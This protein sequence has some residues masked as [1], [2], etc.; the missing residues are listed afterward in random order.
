MRPD[1]LGMSSYHVPESAGLLKLDAMENPYGLP[2]GLRQALGRRLASVAINRY[3][4]PAYAD[5]K[6]S[7]RRCFGVPAAA[8]LVLGNGSDELITMLVTLLNRPGASILAPLPSFVMYAMTAQFARMEFVG[9]DLDDSFQIDLAATL[10]AIDRH[11]PA[12]VFIAYPN[13]PTGNCF[14]REAVEAILRRAPGLVVLDEAY[15]PFAPDSWLSRLEEFPNLAIMRTLSKLGL[16]GAR[17]GYLVAAPAWTDQVEKVRPPYNISVL[18]EAAV[19]FALEHAD[20]FADQARSIRE[21]RETVLTALGELV[22]RGLERVYPSQANFVLVRVAQAP[23]AGGHVPAAA[24]VARRMRE[25]GVLIKDVGKM[26]PMLQNCLR[27]TVGT[28]Q[29]NQTLL[30]ALRQALPDLS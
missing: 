26:H 6:T 5:L 23:E 15:E 9:V 22:G 3:P 1:I 28:R 4:A 30:A 14:S 19:G 16:A 25:Y 12:L 27:L 8:G 18:N 11:Q 29:E 10:S 2:D 21:E 20:V 17:L 7:I 13:N 24:A